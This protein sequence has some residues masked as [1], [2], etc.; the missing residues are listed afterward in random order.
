MELNKMYSRYGTITFNNEQIQDIT[1]RFVFLS[2]ST[3]TG[4]SVL[5]DYIIKG[6]KSPEDIAYDLYGSCDYVW[7]LLL[8]N[9]II[10][11]FE[12]WLRTDEEMEEYIANKYGS[13]ADD[14]HHYEYEGIIYWDKPNAIIGKSV[15]SVTNSQYEFD[16]NEKKRKIKV[17]IPS[18]IPYIDEML[19]TV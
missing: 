19:E 5:T 16:R 9:N 8:C 4:I 6:W 7:I 13:K 10:N 11:P 17:V 18:I 3:P 12:D 2:E 14:I 15:T 1:K